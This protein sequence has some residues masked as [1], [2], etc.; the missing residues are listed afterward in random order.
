MKNQTKAIILA[1]SAVLMWSTVATAFK[2]A[3]SL[4]DIVSLLFYSTGISFLVLLFIAV[5]TG[6][7]RQARSWN[8]KDYLRSIFLGFLNPFLYYL[9]LF[10]AY[11]LLP[12]QEALTL[13]YSWAV[14]IVLLSIPILKQKIKLKS[15]IAV[16]IS[17]IGVIIIATHG[18]PFSLEFSNQLGVALAVGSSVIWS[19]F[20]IYNIKDERENVMKLVFNFLFGFIFISIYSL[21]LGRPAIVDLSAFLAVTYVGLFEMGI[22]F[23]LWLTAIKL[24]ETTA[25]VSNLIYLSPFISLMLINLVLGEKILPSTFVGL[26]LIIAGIILQN[27]K[28]KKT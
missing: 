19:I 23:V 8:S 20:W 9:V 2:I 21:L 5:I 3:L 28:R 16:L 22:T 14:V 24:S 15:I 12:A 7:L 17:F 26:I 25:Q 27:Y 4:I 1:L 11:S 6:R 13:N 18:E 10:K